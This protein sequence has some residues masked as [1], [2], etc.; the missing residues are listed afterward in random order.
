MREGWFM[1]IKLDIKEE[2]QQLSD[3]NFLQHFTEN[4]TLDSLVK[5]AFKDE[6]TNLYN[7]RF[8]QQQFPR[9]VS[10]HKR[11]K[12]KMSLAI[13]DIDNFKSINDSLGHF[14]GNKML[15]ELAELINS[16]CRGYDI[17]VRFGGDEFV[18]LL[19]ETNFG[20]AVGWAKK[21]LELIKSSNFTGPAADPGLTVS[22][23]LC[24]IDF[25]QGVPLEDN[26]CYYL[27]QADQALLL[28]K[29]RGKNNY[30]H[31]NEVNAE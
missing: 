31:Y 20:E 19:T 8:L 3:K 18:I 13:L 30:L 17:A 16:H 29:K 23:G 28:A 25:E 21:L 4:I 15:R 7:Y 5:M 27:D 12:R 11:F 9:E 22:L 24:T 2:R 14:A 6:V 1:S 10:R 26:L